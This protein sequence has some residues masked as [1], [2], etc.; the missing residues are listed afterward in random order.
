MQHISSDPL[1]FG[2]CYS[3]SNLLLLCHCSKAMT[4]NTRILSAPLN[5]ATEGVK[6]KPELQ[7]IQGSDDQKSLVLMSPLLQKN[8]ISG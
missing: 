2:S 1:I 3:G 8:S 5:N 4:K 6:F 7:E